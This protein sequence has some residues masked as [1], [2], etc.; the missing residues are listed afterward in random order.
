MLVGAS[1]RWRSPKAPIGSVGLTVILQERRQRPAL[2]FVLL[3]GFV[4]NESESNFHGKGGSP[5]LED[6][7]LCHKAKFRFRMSSTLNWSSKVPLYET[8]S[9]PNS[10]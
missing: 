2:H 5:L 1:H 6:C 7:Q 8:L 3:N 9:Q 10:M 4:A